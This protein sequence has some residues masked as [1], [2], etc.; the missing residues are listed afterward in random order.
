MDCNTAYYS[1]TAYSASHHHYQHH[2]PARLPTSIPPAI[3]TVAIHIQHPD[4]GPSF[5]PLQPHLGYPIPPQ[6]LDEDVAAGHPRRRPGLVVRPASH[7]SSRPGNPPSWPYPSPS[8]CMAAAVA[9]ESG[10]VYLPS[11]THS[12]PRPDEPLIQ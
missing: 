1:N 2:T 10:T 5:L 12:I 8:R 11:Y 7:P 6:P 9:R 4:T 3:S